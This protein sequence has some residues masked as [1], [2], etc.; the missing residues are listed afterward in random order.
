MNK[1]LTIKFVAVISI[2]TLII[3]IITNYCLVKNKV[4]DTVIPLNSLQESSISQISHQQSI[5]KQ[6]RLYFIDLS[7]RGCKA[8][9][10]DLTL[11]IDKLSHNYDIYILSPKANYQ[12]IIPLKLI[13]SIKQKDGVYFIYDKEYVH[14]NAFQ[15]KNYPSVFEI[16]KARHKMRIIRH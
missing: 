14:F 2:L 1:T 16:D 15:V 4:S 6:I 10:N 11:E 8:E 7:C 3:L 13:Q 12:E 9:L 5:Y